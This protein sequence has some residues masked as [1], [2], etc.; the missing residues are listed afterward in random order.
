[1]ERPEHKKIEWFRSRN[2]RALSI[3]L[4]LKSHSKDRCGKYRHDIAKSQS[5]A[6]IAEE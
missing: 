5:A 2:E 6:Q 1:M 4:F 3:L